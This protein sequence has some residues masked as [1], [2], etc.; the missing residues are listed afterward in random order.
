MNVFIKIIVI[1]NI[2][3]II[4]NI[5]S[6]FKIMKVDDVRTP[7][8]KNNHY[9]LKIESKRLISG[10]FQ[11]KF[12]ARQKQKKS[13]YGYV[14][15]DAASTLKEV[16]LRIRNKLCFIQSQKDFR[17]THLYS[18]GKFSELDLDLNFIIF[19]K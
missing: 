1:T 10:N 7:L 3:T 14:L 12:F 15:V 19:N 11:V 9:D 5:N 13:F 18:I 17:Q 4:A 2:F 16:V 8:I 6:K